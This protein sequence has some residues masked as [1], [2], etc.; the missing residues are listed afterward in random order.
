MIFNIFINQNYFKRMPSIFLKIN[1]PI[2]ME[3]PVRKLTLK[4]IKTDESRSGG[5]ESLIRLRI[6]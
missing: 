5:V 2:P 4:L 1:N 6:P 3:N